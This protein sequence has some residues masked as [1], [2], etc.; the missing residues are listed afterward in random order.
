[1]MMM[2]MISV[3]SFYFEITGTFFPLFTAANKGKGLIL[4]LLDLSAAFD[5]VD[6]ETLIDHLKIWVSI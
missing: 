4:L 6:H 5:L 2:M 3:T 1:M